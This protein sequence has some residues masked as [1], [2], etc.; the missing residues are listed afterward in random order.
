[1]LLR[2]KLSNGDEDLAAF[3]AR[4]FDDGGGLQR[5]QSSPALPQDAASKDKSRSNKTS[6]SARASPSSSSKSSST[7]EGSKKKNG[8]ADDGLQKQSRKQEEAP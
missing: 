5:A 3:E 7:R 1:M 8:G 4:L 2:A 6:K